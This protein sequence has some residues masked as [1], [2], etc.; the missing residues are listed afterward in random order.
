M[1]SMVGVVQ[2]DQATV[3]KVV[4]NY[5]NTE[6]YIQKKEK[7]TKDSQENIGSL[8]APCSFPYSA[9]APLLVLPRR[10]CHTYIQFCPSLES[11]VT[12]RLGAGVHVH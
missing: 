12:T 10:Y 6:G 1:P 9:R 4:L 7:K 8:L 2:N 3:A 11:N 5:G